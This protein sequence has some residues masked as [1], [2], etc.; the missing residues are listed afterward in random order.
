MFRT[1]EKL[2]VKIAVI[3][4]DCKGA[5]NTATGSES[6]CLCRGSGEIMRQHAPKAGKGQP[7]GVILVR[8]YLADDIGSR[9]GGLAL[10][11]DS[12][13]LGLVRCVEAK[14]ARC[15]NGVTDVVARGWQKSSNLSK[16]AC[17]QV[18]NSLCLCLHLSVCGTHVAGCFAVAC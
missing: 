17:L 8:L 11:G 5:S 13:S 6:C 4:P 15:S 10:Q 3:C 12:G 9:R 14:A 16:C 2:Q 18:C 1:V 7:G